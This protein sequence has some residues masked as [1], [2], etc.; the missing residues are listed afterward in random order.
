MDPSVS[1][2]VGGGGTHMPEEDGPRLEDVLPFMSSQS[3]YIQQLEGE[4][5]F[6]KVRLSP[7]INTSQNKKLYTYF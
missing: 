5:V 6:C 2:G 3:A 1:A 7:Q 4:N